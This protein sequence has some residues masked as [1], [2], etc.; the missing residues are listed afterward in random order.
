MSNFELTKLQTNIPFKSMT[1]VAHT[2]CNYSCDYCIPEFYDGTYRWLKD[3]SHILKLVKDFRQDKPLRF[4][5]MGGE[6]TLWPKFKDFCTELNE[7]GDTTLI[8]YTTNGSRTINWWKRYD[9]PT[10][11]V[12]I[13]YHP[14]SGADINHIIEVTKILSDKGYRV[15]IWL[16]MLPVH[17]RHIRK[18][19]KKIA[20]NKLNCI[21][22]PKLVSNWRDSSGVLLSGYTDE[23]LKFCKKRYNN[24]IYPKQ[25]AKFSHN[26]LG[27]DE[28]NHKRQVNV[29]E[30]ISTKK[31]SFRGWMCATGIDYIALEANGD[32][33]GSQCKHHGKLG[34][35]KTGYILPEAPQICRRDWCN[36]GSDIDIYKY[37]K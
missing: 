34:N 4:D 5:I 6:P 17:Y 11:E 9:A 13:T 10:S 18:V 23:M 22:I 26:L 32:I 35:I 15:K 3:Y 36:C 25:E 19:Y 7:T 2:F 28:F 37:I 1:W 29:R 24:L 12:G 31:N 20:K 27:Y 8:M 30:L 16:M 14:I 21:A 33:Y